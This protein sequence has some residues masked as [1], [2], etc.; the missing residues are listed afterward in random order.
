MI[1]SYYSQWSSQELLENYE[2]DA[3]LDH[4]KVEAELEQDEW[5]GVSCPHCSGGCSSCIDIGWSDFI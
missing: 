1:N 4:D 2:I 3:D 5:D